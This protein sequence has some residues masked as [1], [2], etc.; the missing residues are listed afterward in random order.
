MQ[1]VIGRRA[2]LAAG[3]G[4]TV[5][6]ASVALPVPPGNALAFRLIRHSSDIGRHTLTFERQGD[7][8]T[9]RVAVD[10]LV[11]FLSIPI[12]RYALRVVEVW[13]AGTLV[14]VTGETNKNG[15][16]EWV[17]GRRGSDGL[18][19]VGSKTNRYVAPEPAGC[20]S[21]WDRRMLDG[22]MI[23]LED[24]VL[25]RPRVVEERAEDI[26]VASGGM[27]LANRY[28]LSGPF[29]VDLWYDQTDTWASLALTAVDGSHVHYERL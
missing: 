15:R 10:A 17:T 4:V 8:L 5:H 28:N 21:Y 2:V 24:G 7:T 11:S 29:K 14:S 22:A 9:V 6:R 19:V 12:V 25:L 3:A 26:P 23:S 16:R 20:T 13:Q 27:I 1:R 18:V